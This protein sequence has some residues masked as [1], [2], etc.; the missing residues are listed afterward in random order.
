IEAEGYRSVVAVPLVSEG[1]SPG[2][3]SFYFDE[4]RDLSAEE[5]SAVQTFADLAAIA[6]ENARFLSETQRRATTLEILDEI[7]RAI[8]STLDLEELFKTT[9]DQVKRVLPC[10]RASLFNFDR[11]K[12]LVSQVC[13]VDDNEERRAQIAAP[14]SLVGTFFEEILLTREPIHTPDARKEFP[15]RHQTLAEKGLRTI[16][17]V[18][19][20]REGECVGFL[21]VGSEQV[22]AFS[23]EHVDLLKSVADRLA[24]AMRNV[25]LYFNARETSE[26]LDSFIRS[27]TDAIITVDLDGRITSWN[28]GAQAIYGYSEDE[29]VGEPILRI[30]PEGKREFREFWEQ[31]RSGEEVPSVEA[32]RRRK[33]GQL[34]EVSLTVSAI[35]NLD[36]EVV[37]FSGIHRDITEW[38][39][40]EQILRFT[41]FCMD[42][43]G[44]AVFW[45]TSDA[46]IIYANEAACRS[47]QYSLEEL[48]RMQVSDFDLD[49]PFDSWEEHWREV[50]RR[51]AFT[52]ESHHRAKDGR[53]FPVEITVN[54]LEFNGKEYNCAFARDITERK[55][56][57]EML[58]RSQKLAAL[59]RLTAGTAHE[60]LNPANIIGMYAQEMLSERAYPEG[61][62]KSAA[63]IYRNVERIAKICGS[64]RRFSRE[65][66]SAVTEF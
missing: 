34:V 9:V 53:I 43:A 50:K 36:G 8:N 51:G 26:R 54:Y 40:A 55:R 27:A 2:S 46:E 30:Y 14:S 60:I 62:R 18:P 1:V 10:A 17:N 3:M 16:I 42:R 35:R 20:L 4:V 33:D 45:L 64:L 63:A 5:E 58:I 25:E 28:P 48:R 13:V 15:L 61:V 66:K 39:R 65:G 29:M 12:R 11:D 22:D 41:Q 6:L 49:P 56:A 7:G 37:G 47:L 59:G 23:E 31:L 38:K 52:L 57:E 19:I 44:D 32:V 21:N 24:I